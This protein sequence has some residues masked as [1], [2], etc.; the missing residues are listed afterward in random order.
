MSSIA[1][2]PEV[3]PHLWV[4]QDLSVKTWD[5]IEPWY[6]KLLDRE[7][8]SVSD[9]ETWLRDLGELNGVVSQ[10]GVERYV[11]MTCQ[12]DDAEREAAHL[13]WV[14]DI[15]PR[16]KPLQDALRRK[17]LD[18]P[19]RSELP[20]DRYQ[21][22]DR[23]QQNRRT[24]YREANIPRETEVAELEQ[25]YQKIIGAMTVTF[26]GQEYTPAQ[27]APFLEEIDRA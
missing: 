11:A 19:F 21:V 20:R 1:Y 23:A 12:T 27:M 18:S 26:R 10:E 24:L 25:Q 9:L 7:L 4:P 8:P 14:R 2:D 17:Y 5:E 13:A 6:Q 3:F 15:E 16:L 22:F